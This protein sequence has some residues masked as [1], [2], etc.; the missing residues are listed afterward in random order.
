MT[1]DEVLALGVPADKVRA[2]QAAYMKDLNKLATKKRMEEDENYETRA[3]IAA[4]LKM[5]KRRETLHKVLQFI[6][7]EYFREV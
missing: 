2:F 1:R 3:A 6:N 5:I 4:M 7:K